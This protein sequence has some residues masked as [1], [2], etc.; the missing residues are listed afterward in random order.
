[1]ED[2]INEIRNT[3]SDTSFEMNMDSIWDFSSCKLDV[4]IE[5]LEGLYPWLE[6][7]KGTRGTGYKAAVII[8]RDNYA[9]AAVHTAFSMIKSLPVEVKL[10]SDI[11]ETRTWL[12][13]N[14]DIINNLVKK[15]MKL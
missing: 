15:L 10:F 13:I 11:M 3:M 8:N 4:S 7:V 1:M 6:S 12:G 9:I 5:K 2:I 14:E